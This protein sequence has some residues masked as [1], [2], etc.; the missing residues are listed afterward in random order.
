M[1]QGHKEFKHCPYRRRDILDVLD[2]SSLDSAFIVVVEGIPPS[3]GTDRVYFL[4]LFV[5][6]LLFAS[7][8][9]PWRDT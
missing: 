8:E 1:E 9:S 2:S 6:S 7:R 5:V 4:L 3:T